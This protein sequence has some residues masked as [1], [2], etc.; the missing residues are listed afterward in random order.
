MMAVNL[1]SAPV[2]PSNAVMLTLAQNH[3]WFFRTRHPHLPHGLLTWLAVLS[4]FRSEQAREI[5]AHNLGFNV[6]QHALC[7]IIPTVH[8]PGWV[9]REKRVVPDP[10]NQQSKTVV[11]LGQVCLEDCPIALLEKCVAQR[12]KQIAG[13]LKDG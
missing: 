6:L 7:S 4:I 2:S 9:H 10:V 1:H 5:A 12:A 8:Q 13:S 11:R 3:S